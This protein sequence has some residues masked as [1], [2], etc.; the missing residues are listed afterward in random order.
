MC[1][2][3][4]LTNIFKDGGL[5]FDKFKAVFFPHLTMTGDEKPE[6][7]T[8]A[9]F[10]KLRR[11]GYD[12]RPEI[13]ASLKNL[14]R[15]IRDRLQNNFNSV[16]KAFLNIDADFDGYVTPDDIMSFFGCNGDFSYDDL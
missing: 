9:R 6:K 8:Q 4:Y 5:V 1:D 14:E 3:F 10:N 7:S 15:M 13:K 2:F 12:F 11:T 16:R